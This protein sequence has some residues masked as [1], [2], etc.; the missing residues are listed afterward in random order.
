MGTMEIYPVII[1]LSGESYDR[2]R[3]VVNKAWPE[4]S[5]R[6][7]TNIWTV[8][9]SHTLKTRGSQRII[10]DEGGL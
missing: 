10:E 7:L 8:D 6:L 9:Q 4:L 3:Q 5:K 1:I 2:V